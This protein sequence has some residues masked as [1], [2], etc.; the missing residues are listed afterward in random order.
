[1]SSVLIF[2][3]FHLIEFYFL[4][5]RETTLP[6]FQASPLFTFCVF[7]ACNSEFQGRYLYEYMPN[8]E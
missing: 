3:L 7:F 5:S 2:K 6:P 1:M 8:E 4:P